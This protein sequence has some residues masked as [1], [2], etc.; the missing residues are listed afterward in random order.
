LQA[1]DKPRSLGDSKRLAS[2]SF[3]LQIGHVWC[4]RCQG[5][6]SVGMVRRRIWP[7][8]PNPNGVTGFDRKTM[9]LSPFRRIQPI[10]TGKS[11]QKDSMTHL[12]QSHKV[13]IPFASHAIRIRQ[14]RLSQPEMGLSLDTREPSP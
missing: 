3:A 6:I 4:V 5:R 13:R 7:V 2:A 14:L 12:T 11:S 8:A 1:H 9:P 10:P